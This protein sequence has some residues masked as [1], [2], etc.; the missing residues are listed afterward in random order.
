MRIQL[1]LCEGYRPEAIW[2]VS[3]RVAGGCVAVSLNRFNP[4]GLARVGWFWGNQQ[5]GGVDD[6]KRG[7]GWKRIK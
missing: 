3:L 6:G 5:K 7:E 4:S 2:G 1:Y